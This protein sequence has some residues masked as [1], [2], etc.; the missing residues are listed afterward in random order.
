MITFERFLQLP[1]EDVAALVKANGPKVCVF[2]FNGTRRWFL[3]EHSNENHRELSKTYVEETIKGYIRLYKMLFDHGIETVVAPV[4]GKN[5]LERGEEYMTAIGEMMTLFTDHPEFISF[6]KACDVRVRFYG[7]YRKELKTRY[8]YIV[9]AFDKG[10]ELTLAH[11]KHRLLYG[12]FADD[13]AQSIAE[14]SVQYYKIHNRPPSS[15]ELIEMYYGE[16]LEKADMFIGFEKFTV[17]DYPMLNTGN[18]SLYFTVAPS[19]Y[20]TETLL[21]KILF[22]HIYLRPL[23][24]PDYSKTSVDDLAAMRRAYQAGCDN[25]FGIG[26]VES[27]VWYAKLR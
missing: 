6:Y 10:T 8:Q 11:R 1:T 5:I 15:E 17:F 9:E 22:D 20:M 23:P 13:A 12:V 27:G 26:V 7:D 2:P 25:A 19:L 21:R 24:D 3:L 4:F 16:Q 18:E 14:L